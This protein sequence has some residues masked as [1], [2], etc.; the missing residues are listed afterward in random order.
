MQLFLILI[1]KIHNYIDNH[2]YVQ[3]HKKEV[4]QCSKSI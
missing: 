3:S 2:H 4:S 1:K